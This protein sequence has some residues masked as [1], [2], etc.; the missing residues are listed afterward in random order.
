MIHLANDG[1]SSL[2]LTWQKVAFQTVEIGETDQILTVAVECT[3]MYDANKGILTAVA[4]SDC[5]AQRAHWASGCF[6]GSGLLLALLTVQ[7][8]LQTSPSSTPSTHNRRRSLA[9]CTV[10]S[11]RTKQRH[12]G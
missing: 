2:D 6:Y 3:P 10:N 12:I 5:S 7:L 8:P 11:S 4:K 9:R 1:N